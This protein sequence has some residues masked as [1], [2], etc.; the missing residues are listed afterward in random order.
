MR[1][2]ARTLLH[3]VAPIASAQHGVITYRQLLSAEVSED[4]V[5]RWV[6]KGLLHRVHRGVY[7]LGHLAPSVEATYLAAV[8][9]G[10]EDVFLA[11][12]AAAHLYAVTRAKSP[13]TPEVLSARELW[14]PGIWAR[15]T[16]GLHP[17]DVST[18]RGIPVTTLPRTIADL[19][20]VLGLDDLAEA[21]H[22]ADVL[23]HMRPEAV[24]AVLAR[25][26]TI[27]GAG[28][29]RLVV[30]GDA[31]I[32]L[33]RLEK[34]FR[35]LLRR[36]RLPLARANRPAGAHFVDC[37]WPEHRLTVEL[38][39]YRFHRS[40]RAWERDQQRQRAAYARG[41]QFRSYTYGD[42]TERPEVVLGE[43]RPLLT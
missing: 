18:Y 8:L 31:P 22:H 13:P 23:H 11:G 39:S 30:C 21:A 2:Q 43:L 28:K 33:S 29:V 5:R 16:R 24:D 12:C 34:D 20:A 35:T 38:N 15:R 41:D 19:A 36:A 17:L 9:A 3:A 7:R 6:A 10:G 42:V 27:R 40:R 26:P 14:I 4:Q 25:H 32:L 1:G 37:R